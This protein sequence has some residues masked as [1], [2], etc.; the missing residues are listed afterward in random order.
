MGFFDRLKAI[1]GAKLEKGLDAVEDPKEM[2][3]LS[4][5]KMEDSLRTMAMSAVEVGTAKKKLEIQRDTLNA[6]ILKYEEQAKKALEFGQEELAREALA[7]KL[8]ASERAEALGVQIAGMD[9]H[10]QSI[11]KSR[12]ELKYKIESFRAKKEELKAVYDASRAQL[13]IKQV[14]TLVGSE[15]ESVGR[16]IDRAEARIQEMRARVMALDDL[17]AQGMVPEVFPSATDA[18]GRELSRLS[19]TAVVETELARLKAERAAQAG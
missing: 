10:L 19:Q 2:L 8:Q 6:S 7:K 14:M 11:A 3:D 9:Q 15:A 17:V 12:E 16:I 1:V 4:L 5:V 18:I 13:K